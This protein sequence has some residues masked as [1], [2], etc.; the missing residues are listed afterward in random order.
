MKPAHA[1][2]DALLAAFEAEVARSHLSED[3]DTVMAAT[4]FA[5]EAHAEVEDLVPYTG[6]AYIA[7]PIAVA[8]VLMSYGLPL[9]EVLAALLHDVLENTKRTRDHL[10]SSFAAVV[11]SYV[12]EVTNISKREDGNRALRKAI[13]LA[14]LAKASAGG[15]NVKLGDV[16]VNARTVAE[17]APR[18]ARTYLPEK[19]DQ[20][21]VLTK[22]DAALTSAARRAVDAGIEAL[23]RVE[24]AAR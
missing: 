12:V 6:E 20:L 5:A 11:T 21:A 19:R 4:R 10:E 9:A 22:G 18:F 15:N 16:L 24:A 3:R 23:D 2:Y 8:L 7:H 13:D 14:H 1:D 17:R